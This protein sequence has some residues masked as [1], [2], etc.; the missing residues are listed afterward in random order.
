VGEFVN[1]YLSRWELDPDDAHDQA[2]KAQPARDPSAPLAR[3]RGYGPR[4]V[5]LARMARGVR[6]SGGHRVLTVRLKG[7]RV[8]CSRTENEPGDPRYGAGAG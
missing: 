5:P 1:N 3:T 6:A 8:R 4:G 7:R 2:I